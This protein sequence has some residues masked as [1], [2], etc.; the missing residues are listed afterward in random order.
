MSRLPCACGGKARFR[1]VQAKCVLSTVGELTVRRRYFA[2]D[3]CRAKQTPMDAWAGIGPRMLSEHTRRVV[4]LAG[5]S[6]PFDEASSKLKELCHLRISDDTIERVCQEEGQRCG[7]WTRDDPTTVQ[8]MRDAEGELEFSADGVKVNTVDGWSEMRLNI[9]AKRP[10]AAPA[11]PQQWDDRVLPDPTA[12]LA[13]NAIAPCDKVGSSW[14]RMFKHLKVKRDAPLSVV[15]DGAKW[16]WDQAAKRLP[17]IN[18]QWVVDIY[19]V[20]QHLHDCGKQLFGDGTPAAR[21]WAEQRRSELI[22]SGGPTFIAGLDQRIRDAAS[23]D[24][25]TA[26]TRLRN[27]L[28]DNAESLWYRQRLAEGKTI[29]SGMIEGGCKTI[30][31]HRLKRNNAR[32]QPRRAER[33]ANLRCL[34]YNGCWD[35]FWNQRAA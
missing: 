15:A 10:R 32:W 19:H 3:A 22:Q 5:S 16:I 29:G 13:W 27:Y 17:S 34:Q 18:A 25:A 31:A 30:I 8:M 35:A 20:S 26:L 4:T 2:C 6:W 23:P 14:T 11:T 1:C 7:R 28:H 33:I 21:R 24:H 9:L 12:R